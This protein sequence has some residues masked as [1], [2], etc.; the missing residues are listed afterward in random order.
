MAQLKANKNLGQHFLID[1][2]VV[3]DTVEE[4]REDE[5]EDEENDVQITEE[6]RRIAWASHVGWGLAGAA[7]RGWRW[8]S[9]ALPRGGAS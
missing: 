4:D 3:L 7:Q 9:R 2:G 1:K 8:R 5:D 6:Q